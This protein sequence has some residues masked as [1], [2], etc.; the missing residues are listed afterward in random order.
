M[1]KKRDTDRESDRARFHRPLRFT[2]LMFGET[3]NGKR[4]KRS[5]FESRQGNITGLLPLCNLASLGDLEHDPFILKRI[6]R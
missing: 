4:E 6:Q 1:R 2:D 3:A 5:M